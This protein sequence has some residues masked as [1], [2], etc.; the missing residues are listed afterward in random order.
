MADTVDSAPR[1]SL[2]AQAPGERDARLDVIRGLALI[3]IYINHV[4]GTV[5]EHFT[6]R[7]YGFSD[8]AEA[9]VLMS[10]IAAGLAYAGVMARDAWAGTRR[11]WGRAWTLYLVHMATTMMAIGISAAA[12]RWFGATR[13]IEINNMA[14]FF[15]D[16]IGVMI[17]LPTLMHQ[18]G[19]FNILPLYTVLLLATPGM[20]LIGRSRPLLL[21]ALS[22]ALWFAAGNLRLNLPA[23]PNPGGWFFNPL[24]WQLVFVVGLLTGLSLKRGE[25]LVPRDRRLLH[26]A[27]LFLL[28]VLVWRLVPP[29]AA[30]GRAMVHAGYDA[31]VPFFIAGFDKT[32]L[33]LP[34]AL[35]VL[36]LFY[37]VSMLP[38]V[39]AMASSGWAAPVALLGRFGLPVFATGS[40]LSIVGQSI[41]A[42]TEDSFVLDAW[43]ITGGLAIQFLVA[44]AFAATAARREPARA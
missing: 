6:S 41:K 44:A 36:A 39:G 8:A 4:P 14:A 29:V 31:G 9:F 19:Y 15:D 18:L 33:S 40:V 1:N 11:I 12:A 43:I 38:Q 22:L 26:V 3:T 37:V 24:A 20:I 7:N 23:Y 28:A 30:A 32:F 16:Q 5:F 27:V 42:A 34:R 25:R 17:G 21:L 2:V 10:G 35:H 13:M